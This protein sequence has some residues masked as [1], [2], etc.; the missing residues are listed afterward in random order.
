[1]PR[2]NNSMHEKKGIC[3][4]CSIM[5]SMEEWIALDVM[6]LLG[7]VSKNIGWNGKAVLVS[8]H[9]LALEKNDRI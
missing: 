7:F 8:Y 1:M 2:R 5:V 6:D 9:F 3:I 4:Y